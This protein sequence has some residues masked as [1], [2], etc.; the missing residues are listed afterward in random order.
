MQLGYSNVSGLFYGAYVLIFNAI[1]IEPIYIL[2]KSYVQLGT[3]V[4]CF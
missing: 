1:V 4:K 2:A 3:V